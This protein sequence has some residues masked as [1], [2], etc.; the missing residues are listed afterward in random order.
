VNKS[1]ITLTALFLAAFLSATI[2]ADDVPAQTSVDGVKISV[3]AEYNGILIDATKE[4]SMY[5]GGKLKSGYLKSDTVIDGVTYK[6]ASLIKLFGDGKVWSGRIKTQVMIGGIPFKADTDISFFASGKV[7]AGEVLSGAAPGDKNLILPVDLVAS[8]SEDGSA[9]SF[10]ST[11]EP[12]RILDFTVAGAVTVYFDKVAGVYRVQGGNNGVPKIVATLPVAL[13][14]F[15]RPSKVE[16][17]IAP[18]NSL[19]TTQFDAE[20]SYAESWQ[21]KGGL[22]LNG[23]NLGYNP[24]LYIKD[25]AIVKFRVAEAVKINGVLIK[26]GT[27]LLLDR[28][29]KV[30]IPQP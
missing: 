26:A 12:Y 30:Y 18:A 14:S 25:M 5:Y 1:S 16:V 2:Q 29:G 23:Q 24:T 10:F 9:I 11:G 4:V 20:E 3:D 19:L 21:I 22:T 13:D 6:A 8:F 17:V 27:F 7:S 15:G 28:V